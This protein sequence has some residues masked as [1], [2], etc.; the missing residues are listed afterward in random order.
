MW[1]AI[2]ITQ[3]GPGLP[4]LIPAIYNYM[5]SGDIK[6]LKIEDEDIPNDTINEIVKQ[7]TFNCNNFKNYNG[8]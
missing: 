7:V 8:S 4:V 6:S 1:I 2:S 3:G 5:T